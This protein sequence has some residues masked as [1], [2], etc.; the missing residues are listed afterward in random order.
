MNWKEYISKIHLTD[1][2]TTFKFNPPVTNAVLQ[3]L[4]FHLGLDEL[5]LELEELYRQ[6]NGI[7]QTLDGQ[8][9]GELIWPASKAVQINRE[10]RSQ[11]D[12][13]NLYMSFDQL[14][15]ISDAGNGDLFGFVTL[16]GKFYRR[17][18]FVWNHEDDSRTWVAP[19]LAKFIE[20]WADGT[21]SV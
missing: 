8:E 12:F 15:S 4:L 14:F 1:K 17:D 21:I 7:E 18:I 3:D 13:K 9:I 16:N 5:P 19:D 10:Y 2:A 11:P 20:W 6:A